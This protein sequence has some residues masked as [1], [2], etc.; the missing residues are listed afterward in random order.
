MKKVIGTKRMKVTND[1]TKQSTIP[2]QNN[3]RNN[4][5]NNRNNKKMTEFEVKY[6]KL[7]EKHPVLMFIPTILAA[8]L[9]TRSVFLSLIGGII[10]QIAIN[11]E[12]T[13]TG[14]IIDLMISIVVIEV[15]HK[16][17]GK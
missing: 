4:N 1:R 6:R 2:K 12:R 17:T 10:Y 14:F 3:I 15:W 13:L 16:I 11:P 5:S 9:S 8:I 7:V